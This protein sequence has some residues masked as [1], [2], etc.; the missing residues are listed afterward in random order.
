LFCSRG[1]DR[2]WANLFEVYNSTVGRDVRENISHPLNIID[3]E[4]EP[5][6]DL[7]K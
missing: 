5:L 3:V 7:F 4:T 6:V 2:V 1:S